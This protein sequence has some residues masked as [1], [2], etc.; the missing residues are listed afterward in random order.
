MG[1]R[2]WS[3]LVGYSVFVLWLVGTEVYLRVQG[4]VK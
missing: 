4:G 2:C 3:V 1:G